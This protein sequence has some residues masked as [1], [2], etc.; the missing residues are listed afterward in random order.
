MC[1]LFPTHERNTRQKRRC[2]MKNFHLPIN[3]QYNVQRMLFDENSQQV[4]V[5]ELASSWTGTYESFFGLFC[6]LQIEV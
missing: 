3:Y 1:S 4:V 2:G 6:E 5:D